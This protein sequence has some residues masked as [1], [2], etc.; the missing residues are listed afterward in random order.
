MNARDVSFGMALAWV[1]VG[2][3]AMAIAIQQDAGP[4][5]FLLFAGLC[6]ALGILASMLREGVAD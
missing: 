1:L 2:P 6:I 3:V 4:M 5:T